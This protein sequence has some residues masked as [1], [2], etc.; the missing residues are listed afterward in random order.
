MEEKPSLTFILDTSS[1]MLKRAYSSPF[2]STREY[3]GYFDPGAYYCYNT[4]ND[5]PH[6]FADNSTGQ[7]SG[8]FLNWAAMLRIDV[9]RKLLS[10]GKIDPATGCFEIQARGHGSEAFEFDDTE[11]RIDL[12]GHSKHMT[13][14]RGPV[15]IKALA[16]ESTFTVSTADSEERCALSLKGED[17]KGL[18]QSVWNQA[19]VALVTVEDGKPKW[20]PPTGY[21][22]N[23]KE[24]EDAVNSV[25]P[26]D[27]APLETILHAVYESLRQDSGLSA[28]AVDQVSELAQPCSR[29]RII[30]VSAERADLIELAS[31]AHTR[32]IRLQ[33]GM[34]S[35]EFYALS[36]ADTSFSAQ[37]LPDLE[38]AITQTSLLDAP[39]VA[40]GTTIA[41]ST[42][43]CTGEGAAYQAVF[44]PP[45][46][47]D[48]SV[49][50]WSGEVRACL[51]D[52]KGNLREASGEKKT[53][54]RFIELSGGTI[55]VHGDADENGVIDEEE[56]NATSLDGLDGIHFLWSAS[57]WLNQL[58]DEQ[59]ITQRSSYTSAD[60]NRFILTFVDRDQDMVADADDGEIQDFALPINPTEATLNVPDYFYNYLTLYESASGVLEL[61]LTDSIQ[62]QIH[63][64][65]KD[66]PSEFANFQATVAKRQ[67]DFIRGLDIGNA[68]IEGI[69]DEARSRTHEGTTWRLGDIVHSS[70]TAVGKP[71]E[72]YHLIYNDSTYETFLRKYLNRRQVVYVGANNG[73]L[74]AFNGGFWN[75]KTRTFD[76][77]RDGLTKFTLGQELWGYVPYNLLPHLKWL[78]HPE[79]GK[80]LH[81]AY[82]DL[83]PKVFDA[84]IFVMSDG[85]TSVDEDKYPGGWG[86]ILVAGM[87]LGGAAMEVDIDKTDGNVFNKNIDRT[88]TSAYVIMDVT[89]P[90]SPPNVLA[91]ISLPDQGFTTCIPAVMPMSS[92]NA[93]HW[94][95]NKWFMVFGSGPAAASGRGDRAK[96]MHEGSDPLG[97]L[98][99]LD[100]SALYVEKIVKTVD[101][102]GLTSLQGDPFAIAEA[103]SIISDPACVDLDVGAK[104]GDGEFSTDLVYFGTVAGNSIS[105]T[106]KI[107]R[108]RT[109][110]G[111]PEEWETSILVDVEEPV[112]AAPAVAVDEGSSLWIYFGTGR[113]FNRDDIPQTNPKGFYGIREP[114][115][116]GVRNW[117]TVLIQQL[118]DSSKIAMTRG[119]CG[120]GEFSDDCVGIIQTDE[121]SN[122]TRDWA[123]LTSALDQAPGWK[124]VFSDA[125]ERVLSPAAILGGLVMFTS[126]TP[127]QEVCSADGTSRLWALYYKTGTPY[128]W[129]SLGHPAGNFPAFIELG[130]GMAASP[131][132][133]IDENPTTKAFTQLTTGDITD[134]EIDTPIPFKSGC[135]FWRKNVE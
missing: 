20:Y 132:L 99:V 114:E 8:N 112:S 55:F 4:E 1:S 69:D 23:L 29:Q 110:N 3:Y 98:F 50:A 39:E 77:E 17:N 101:S 118:F 59:A 15:T 76:D 74:H 90:E 116:G 100:L 5:T 38:R 37:S 12:L 109:G 26:Q 80:N 34:R 121:N 53:A 56:R 16:G 120:E 93:K 129:P 21:A 91:E 10:G 27:T 83:T 64:L 31:Q 72:N 22:D 125:G 25:K 135:L 43:T 66:K 71:A 86:T 122:S 89:D 58:D 49:P 68:T 30:L 97:K 63:N 113:F 128:F 92:P 13:P 67:V 82:M 73:M 85:I 131:T 52:A 51:V 102:T 130:P 81:V 6:F 103:G 9:A 7:W 24:L 84:R 61:D 40:S 134:A 41:V 107:Y 115:T 75:A 33:D 126:F 44:Y 95:A 14:L 42:Q 65:R 46:H 87:R 127:T 94:D 88:V 35:V 117:D 47:A 105:P 70:P 123:W 60:P 36:L 124:H 54:G 2:N 48:R 79:Y 133:H 32:N 111:P 57:D 19:R 96:L 104:N 28:R 62:K 108:L 119:T 78:M 11:P 106:G 18:L 45:G